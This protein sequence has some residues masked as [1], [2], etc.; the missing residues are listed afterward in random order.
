[1]ETVK[2]MAVSSPHILQLE[3]IN[4]SDM[5]FDTTENAPMK[6]SLDRD[7]V[8]PLPFKR[9]NLGEWKEQPS[10][11]RGTAP[12][13]IPDYGST[14]EFYTTGG[15][16]SI[17][18]ESSQRIASTIAISNISSNSKISV[19]DTSS[20]V[21]TTRA[22]V[23]VTSVNE[24]LQNKATASTSAQAPVPVVVKPAQVAM[25]MFGNFDSDS[26]DEEDD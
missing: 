23:S 22:E 13:P 9:P 11:L 14:N 24:S 21:D 8:E 3:H 1:M 25:S 16:E 10:A 6:R 12:N 2:A 7:D 26:S 4:Q 18:S 15:K 20:S 17:R 19:D 5:S